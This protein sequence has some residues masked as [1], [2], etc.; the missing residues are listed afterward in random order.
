MSGISKSQVSWLCKEIDEAETDVLAYMSF[1][2]STAPNSTARM[3]STRPSGQNRATDFVRGRLRGEERN[4][5][6]KFRQAAFSQLCRLGASAHLRSSLP[7]RDEVLVRLLGPASEVHLLL[8]HRV[9]VISR[10]TEAS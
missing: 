2:R 7:L 4:S 3:R 1:P 10:A 9:I 8:A 5:G 6:C